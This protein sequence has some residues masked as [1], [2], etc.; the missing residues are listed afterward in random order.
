MN[1]ERFNALDEKIDALVSLCAAM[2]QENQMLRTREHNWQTERQ[3]L[4]DNNKLAKSR[5]ESVLNK[6][7]A[8]E[9]S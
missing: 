3:Q 7:K 8:L 5:L 9:Q 6:L 2:K 4:L 1:D